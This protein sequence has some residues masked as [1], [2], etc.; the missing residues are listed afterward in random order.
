[1]KKKLDDVS[2]KLEVLYDRLR[3]N[4]VSTSTFMITL[5][6]NNASLVF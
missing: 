5:E 6:S 2:K 4:S 3:E 1:M